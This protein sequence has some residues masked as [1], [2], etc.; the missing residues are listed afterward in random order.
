MTWNVGMSSLTGLPLVEVGLETAL[1]CYKR[2]AFPGRL[3]LASVGFGR[4]DAVGERCRH[5]G[6]TDTYT[7]GAV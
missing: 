6:L 3:W 4:S 5:G 1:E 2:S 7:A